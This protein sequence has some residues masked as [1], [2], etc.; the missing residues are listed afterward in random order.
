LGLAIACSGGVASAEQQ[1]KYTEEDFYLKTRMFP[2]YVAV[3]SDDLGTV[4]SIVG[5]SRFYQVRKGDTLVDLARFYDLGYNEI[6]QANPGVDPW[7]PPENQTIVLPTEWAL[8][9]AAYEGLVVNIPEMRA[10]YF[11][12]NKGKGAQLVTT[13]PV[14]L[15]R[16]DWRTP[17]GKFR[18]VGKT[19]NPTWVIPESIQKERREEKGLYDKVI[20]GGSPD[21]PLGKYRLELSMPGY[22][23]HGTNIPWGVGWQVSHGCVRMYPED[24]EQLFGMIKVG[25]PGEFVYQP[26]KI[27][28]REGR[29]FAEVHPDIY[30]LTPGPYREAQRILAELKWSDRVDLRRLQRAVEEESGVPLDISL[31]T[32][33]PQKLPE[34]VLRPAMEPP[35]RPPGA[36]SPG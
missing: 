6:V 21:N 10:Y 33:V 17:Q 4:R 23:I 20:P 25:E 32:R 36:Q 18:I 29:I 27:G 7:I 15:G 3:A 13:H 1:G 26:V 12:P 19:V 8:P 5:S 14:G 34:E 30:R 16:D 22:R 11:H 24:I 31:D 9:Q 2:P 35:R 28:A